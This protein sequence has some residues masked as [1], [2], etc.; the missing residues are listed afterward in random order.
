MDNQ[1]NSMP[2]S[3]HN[4]IA[5]PQS[6][7]AQAGTPQQQ[8]QMPPPSLPPPGQSADQFRLAPPSPNSI[9]ANFYSQSFQEPPQ[10]PPPPP[11]PLNAINNFNSQYSKAHYSSPRACAGCNNPIRD[12]HLLECLS[13]FWHIQCLKCQACNCV[14]SEMGEKCFTRDRMILCRDDYFKMYGS[15][16]ISGKCESC[17]KPIHANEQVMRVMSNRVYHVDCFACQTCR[18]RLKPGDKFCYHNNR[19]FCEKDNPIMMMSPNQ[20]APA[21]INPGMNTSP[22]TGS[23][24]ANGSS[25]KR[26][27]SSSKNAL[28]QQQQQQ[29][30]HQQQ[31]QMMSQQQQQQQFNMQHQ[32]QIMSQQQ[33]MHQQHLMYQEHEKL[34]QQIQMQ[35][36]IIN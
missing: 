35:Q 29:M 7:S 25:S 28:A 1:A 6:P 17:T 2:P 9:N 33:H 3:P 26:S 27:K 14:L 15:Q 34:Q 20:M 36:Q 4:S 32:Q 18:T 12:R 13:L 8:S 10:Q 22:P 30:M 16:C 24:R 11:M 23:K 19:I 21:M 5:P 31:Q